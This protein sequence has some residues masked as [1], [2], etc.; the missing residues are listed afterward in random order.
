[1]S[2]NWNQSRL[3]MPLLFQRRQQFRIPPRTGRQRRLP[4][5][6]RVLRLTPTRKKALDFS[7]VSSIGGRDEPDTFGLIGAKPETLECSQK[8]VALSACVVPSQRVPIFALTV[9]CGPIH[10]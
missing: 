9:T 8:T 3:R 6:I 1:M 4:P 10:A 7:R 2:C 5:L